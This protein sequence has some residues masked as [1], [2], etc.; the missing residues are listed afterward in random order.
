MI[1]DSM[2]R[3]YDEREEIRQYNRVRELALLL[4]R[5]DRN[6]ARMSLSAL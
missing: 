4:R 1:Y 6:F 5:D 2:P 3:C